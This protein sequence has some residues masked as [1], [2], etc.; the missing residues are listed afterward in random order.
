MHSPGHEVIGHCWV[1]T[2]QRYTNE[3][4]D[5]AQ[6]LRATMHRRAVAHGTITLP[7]IPAML[8]EYVGMCLTTFG[9]IGVNFDYAQEQDLRMALQGQLEFAF[10]QSPRSEIVI[11][12]D[13]PVG[14]LVNYHVQPKWATIEQTYNSWVANRQPPYFGTEPDA[15]VWELARE[16][17]DPKQCP[18]LDIGAGTGR[19]ALALAR[20]G[21]PVDALEVSGQFADL[22]REQ[23]RSEPVGIRVIQRDLFTAA[24]YLPGDYGLV[25]VSEVTSDFRS[26]DDLRRLFELAAEV[27]VL[28]GV[29]AVS[30][31]V[32]IQGYEPDDAARQVG[33]QT[34]SAIFTPAELERAVSGLPLV[35]VDD[36]S[37]YDFEHDHLPQEAWPP[38][39]WYEGW[40]TGQD[41]FAVGRPNT[42]IELRWLVYRK[43]SEPAA[44]T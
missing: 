3:R 35:L 19:N 16:H 24:D 21:H 40:S 34:Y 36:T 28:D 39:G 27:L 8:E 26:A 37:A 17:D 9:A 5:L 14:S 33:Q 31:F 23:A 13:S 30:A 15:R 22:L 12:Y 38:T 20:R 41:V 2:E 6:A 44:A 11:T 1:M 18:V 10:E 43:K 32:A 42:P 4:A 7:A 25:V 29:I